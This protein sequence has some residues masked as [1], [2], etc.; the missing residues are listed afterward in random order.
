MRINDKGKSRFEMTSYHKFI[1]L[2]N[3]DEYGN[4]PMTTTKD[5]RRKYFMKCSDELK[6]NHKYFDDFYAML[7]NENQMKSVFEYFKNRKI[8]LLQGELPLTDYNK[9]LKALGTP[10]LKQFIKDCAPDFTECELTSADLFDTFLKWIEK[11]KLRYECNSQQFACRFANLRLKGMIK[12]QNIGSSHLKGWV[13]DKQVLY[14]ELEI[15]CMI[16]AKPKSSVSNEK[17]V[18]HVRD[19]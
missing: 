19:T 9:E 17:N 8:T 11:N 6:G 1:A 15:G 16:S 14:D 2:S 7:E 5:D 18:S 4:E 13:I 12:C 3:P 10:V